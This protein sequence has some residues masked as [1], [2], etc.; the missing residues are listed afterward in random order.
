MNAIFYKEWIKTR[1]YLLLALLM[2]L[3][4]AG[5][6]MLRINRVVN[7]KGVEH[8]WEVMLTR[9]ALF[10]DLLE[11][12][13]LLIGILLALVQFMPEMHRKCL[14][15]TLHLPYPQ[16][17]MINLMLLYGLS[18]LL[19]C[20][21]TN[22]LLMGV[23]MQHILAPELYS[24]ILLTALP[25]YLAGI[26]PYLLLSWICLE[27]TWKRRVFNLVISALLLRIFFLAPAPEAYNAFLPWLAIY[28]LFTAC[29]SW[30]S[31][32]RF[33]AGKQD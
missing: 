5:Y 3:G 31:V 18:A 19:I 29:L 27:P 30:S 25:W 33:K 24:R 10:I 4:F 12:I 32:A 11:Y 8:V 16:L 13:P 1:W 6:S 17:R 7:M 26:A 20:F 22:Y 14:K 2:T 15:L 9:D 21:A 28:T 23:Y